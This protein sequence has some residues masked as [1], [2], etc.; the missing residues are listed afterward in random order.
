MDRQQ[1]ISR[2]LHAA[3][4]RDAH[5][6][7]AFLADACAGD[8][9]LRRQVESRL[10]GEDAAPNILEGTAPEIAAPTFTST[11]TLPFASGQ[12]AH[13]RIIEK[14]GA[15]GMGEVYRAR[16]E[17]LDRDVAI[18]VLPASS[19]EDP[20]ARARLVQEAKAAAALNHPHIC[21]VYE[22]GEAHGQAYIAMELVEGQPLSARLKAGAL[23][24]KQVVYYG[25]QLAD[26]LA[27]A[28]ESGVVHRDLKCANVMVRPDGRVKVLDFGLAKRLTTTE[29]TM[30]ITRD[31]A[32]LTE[33]GTVMGTVA[34]MAPEQL[35]GQPAQTTS[36]VW[37]LGVVLHELAGGRRPFEG[38]TG[39]ELSA[40][41]L[42]EVPP[43]L[44]SEIPRPLQTVIGRCLEKEPGQRYQVG[45][46]V[47]AALEA[48]Q[49]GADVQTA[50]T[51]MRSAVVPP[52]A[53]P[54]ARVGLTRRRAIGLGAAAVLVIASG[55]AIQLWPAAAVQSL[56]VLPFENVLND[57][58]SDYLCDGVAE[59]L[60]RQVS[61]LASLHVT[62]L[63]AV[64]NLKGQTVDPFDVGRQLGV[65]TILQGT[66]SLQG[67]RLSITAE[68]IDTNSGAQLWSSTYDRDVTELLTIQD[69]IASAIMDELLPLEQ[70]SD[71][72]QLVR[73]PTDS[74][75][76]Y[77]LYLQARY[78]QRLA[79]EDDYLIAGE[80][81]DRALVEDEE[82]ALAL[83]A[84]A[85]IHTMMAVDDFERPI[86]AR[87]QA[88]RYLRSAVAI[89]PD[90]VEARSIAHTMAFYFDWDWEGAARERRI[91]MQSAAGDFD[92]DS[93]RALAIERWA[94]GRPDE[95]VD[96]ARR[97][98]ELDPLS[99]GL[100]ILE[101][102]Y[103]YHAGQL[104]AAIAVYERTMQIEPDNPEPYFGQ[105]EALHQQGRF[106]E[107]SEARRQAHAMLGT[108][109][110]DV[111]AGLFAAARGEQGY[112]EAHEAYVRQQLE[113]LDERA[114]YGYASPLDF[115]RAHAEL[116][117]KDE[118]FAHLEEAFVDRS[119]SLV[120]LNVD[121]AWDRIRDD[122][123][124]LDAVR[125]VGLPLPD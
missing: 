62:P 94:L 82:F 34:Y 6:R 102:M 123:R 71:E 56:A 49:A 85:G 19:F 22:V 99:T 104:D 95:A 53:I 30:A 47:R 84:Q 86:D 35:R 96:L 63:S 48:V 69:E 114:A 112:R 42:S 122:S 88:S 90:L 108:V 119:P 21:T 110:D 105:A 89:E 68:L 125:R 23:S 32:S 17:Q 40:A 15:G 67:E 115:A 116:G 7:A 83:V 78:Y 106:D 27:H 11:P 121:R 26:A 72:R 36:D 77:D 28:H 111:I 124:F 98:R 107:A 37:A 61:R 79:T 1:Q 20:T 29:L 97:A 74:G 18:K 24:P 4:T 54:P 73:N 92:P 100:S 55:L 65:E 81:L 46:E 76:A 31:V 13:Y 80:L 16:D 87:A 39:F 91:I 50:A 118:A 103:L 109:E 113:W 38:Q 120:K 101:A 70:D 43:P 58:E 33:P 25:L 45:S 3:L 75:E 52:A 8:D 60:I 59:S 5:E 2:I 14:I 66:L 10:G 9:E 93:L 12:L 117:E 64:L 57:E 41:I 44:P 51:E